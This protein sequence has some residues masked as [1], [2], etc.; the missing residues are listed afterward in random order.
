MSDPS[1]P[2]PLDLT[3]CLVRTLVLY[4]LAEFQ[5]GHATTIRVNAHGASFSVADDGRGHAI[6][7]TIGGSP[8]LQFVY[9]HL[10]YPFQTTESAPMQLH[11]LG[12][13]LANTLC[14]ELIVAVR[15]RDAMLRV[16]FRNGRLS[17][18]ERIDA[19]SEAT[20]TTISGTVRPQLQHVGT[21]PGHLRQWL[22]RVRAAHPSLKLYFNDEQVHATH[23]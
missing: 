7:R 22:R 5:S 21:D 12:T 10:D 4:T 19:G 23:G 17:G 3:A 1:R 8:Y 20:G 11:G 2:D 15:K 9:T 6:E 16:T 13:S 14:S 18:E